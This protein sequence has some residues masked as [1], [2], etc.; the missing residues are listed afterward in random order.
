MYYSTKNILRVMGRIGGPVTIDRVA[1][2]LGIASI[3]A[4]K[5]MIRMAQLGQLHLA[6]TDGGKRLFAVAS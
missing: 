4:G 5:A 3:R 2:E 6:G 1:D